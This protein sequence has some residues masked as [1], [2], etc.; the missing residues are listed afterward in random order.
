MVSLRT[1]EEILIF[2]SYFFAWI[3]VPYFVAYRANVA[4]ARHQ[5]EGL[6]R[7]R[8]IFIA[9]CQA[10]E[11]GDADAARRM[12]PDI[13][14]LE[15]ARRRAQSSSAVRWRTAYVASLAG[16]WSAVVRLGPLVVLGPFS[17]HG[18]KALIDPTLW[19][20]IVT[21]WAVGALHACDAFRDP[22][23][24][25]YQVEDLG[26]RLER[27]LNSGRGIEVHE[28]TVGM[29]DGLSD[30]EIFALPNGA[31]R[32][33]LDKA[34]RRL[35]ALYHPDRMHSR[36]H[37]ERRAGEEAMKRVNAAYDRLKAGL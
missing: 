23:Y 16:F 12:L 25:I 9:A 10:L 28:N 20:L 29:F 19:V 37:A 32:R 1:L 21:V 3:L 27:Y 5:N 6:E 8:A 15:A 2:G 18:I 34:R 14:N 26:D 11:N 33:D 35:A 24:S 4:F 7:C 13:R 17:N 36:S 22:F 31:R 30:L